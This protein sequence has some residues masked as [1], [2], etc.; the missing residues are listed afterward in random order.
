MRLS[1]QWHLGPTVR[2]S[3]AVR[4]GDAGWIVFARMADRGVCPGCQRRSRHLHGWRE[5]QLQDFA[6]Q[7]E[8]VT[9][10]LRLR[11]WRYIN[12]T[13]E[14]ETFSDRSPEFVSPFA[15]RTKRAA[16]IVRLLAYSAGG[17]PSERIMH[18]LGMPIS[19]DTIL[20]VL[21]RGLKHLRPRRG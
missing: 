17:R 21:K 2:A 3:H 1:K 16:Q 19:N 4:V 6:W 13:C 8:Q 20:R 7:D 9:I 18:C 11:R 15:R 14:R 12:T 5:R 10:R